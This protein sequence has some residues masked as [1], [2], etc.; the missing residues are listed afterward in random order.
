MSAMRI[1]IRQGSERP[2]I[3]RSGVLPVKTVDPMLGMRGCAQ[4]YAP[5]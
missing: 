2:E 1:V 3:S 5:D 4:F